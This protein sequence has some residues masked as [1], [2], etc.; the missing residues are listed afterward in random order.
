MEKKYIYLLV[1]A[2][3]FIVMIIMYALIDY[4]TVYVEHRT[5]FTFL[6]F[7]GLLFLMIPTILFTYFKWND[8]K[9]NKGFIIMS[10][11]FIA[12]TMIIGWVFIYSLNHPDIGYFDLSVG[13]Y[14]VIIIAIIILFVVGAIVSYL[15]VGNSTRDKWMM[16]VWALSL[17]FFVISRLK[18]FYPM[19]N[20]NSE[21][22]YIFLRDFAFSFR[23]SVIINEVFTLL[24][25]FLAYA[26][27]IVSVVTK[28]ISLSQPQKT[29]E[30]SVFEKN[31]E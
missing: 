3:S 23:L 13:L 6:S 14:Y 17:S 10:G 25:T 27:F 26:G 9:Y 4:D 2:L 28:Y 19:Q 21:G 22:Y 16:N 30:T 7:A 11:G 29:S 31:V 1:V 20:L 24:S 18:N 8:L 15:D 5:L 12:M